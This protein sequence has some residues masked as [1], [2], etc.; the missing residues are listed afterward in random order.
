MLLGIKPAIFNAVEQTPSC[1]SSLN[2]AS[3]EDHAVQENVHQE[4]MRFNISAINLSNKLSTL[5][6]SSR[7][8]IRTWIHSNINRA[9]FK[10]GRSAIAIPKGTLDQC[11]TLFGTFINGQCSALFRTMSWYFGICSLDLDIY[12][13]FKLRR[14]VN[15]LLFISG[16]GDLMERQ[17][18]S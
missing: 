4:Q 5:L 13:I 15:R 6:S 12:L 1:A 16:W 7:I 2:A 8:R 9:I 17:M 10:L 14:K 18:I 3:T 11:S